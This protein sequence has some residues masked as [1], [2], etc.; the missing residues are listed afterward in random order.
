MDTT[1]ARLLGLSLV[2]AVLVGALTLW[3]D[4]PPA[5]PLNWEAASG[6]VVDVRYVT[7]RDGRKFVSLVYAD[8]RTV[9]IGPDVLYGPLPPA[10]FHSDC[11][12]ILSRTE[13][14]EALQ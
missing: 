9:E 14:K 7:Y 12:Q 11:D 1:R 8:G 3:A 13:A 4:E 10:D 2:S 5:K 6:L